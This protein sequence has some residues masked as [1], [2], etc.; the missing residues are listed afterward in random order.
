MLD[1]LPRKESR[2]PRQVVAEGYCLSCR[3]VTINDLIV[4]GNFMKARKCRSC[5]RVMQASRALMAECYADELVDRLGNLMKQA[6]PSKVHFLAI[7]DLLGIPRRTVQKAME[8]AAYVS[9]LLM[10]KAEWPENEDE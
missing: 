6:K 8:E 3:E 10:G 5:G 2:R 4:V 9:D 7:G 1:R